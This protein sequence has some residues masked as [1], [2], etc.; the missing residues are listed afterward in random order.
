[1]KT[2]AV[3]SEPFSI[4]KACQTQAFLM[5][6]VVFIA[7]PAAELWSFEAGHELFGD[8]MNVA[9]AEFFWRVPIFQR[10][11]MTALMKFWPTISPV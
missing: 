4:K 11:V 8:G 9:L 5:G 3:L 6:V 7:R 1:L 2:L 10:K